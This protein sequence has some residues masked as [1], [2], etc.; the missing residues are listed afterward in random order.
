MYIFDQ[1]W[2]KAGPRAGSGPFA[3][4]IRPVE[5]FRIQNFLNSFMRFC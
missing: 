4:F 5:K 3:N 2:A 1:G